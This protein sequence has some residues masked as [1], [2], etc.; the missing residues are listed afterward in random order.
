MASWPFHGL[1]FSH[2]AHENAAVEIIM[3][4]KLFLC[5]IS[6][7]PL[8]GH[9]SKNFS[10]QCYTHFELGIQRLF[11]MWN[12]DF[13][14]AKCKYLLCLVCFCK[15]EG[16]KI[17]SVEL[18]SLCTFLCYINKMAK[19]QW[20]WLHLKTPYLLFWNENRSKASGLLSSGGKGQFTEAWGLK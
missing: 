4:L 13:P 3:T 19:A 18:P 5:V 9:D 6:Q 7:K 15:R 8:S 1:G 17:N 14:L 20:K 16:K 11:Q 12:M 2:V 10:P